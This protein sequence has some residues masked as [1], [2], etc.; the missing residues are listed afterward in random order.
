ME[1]SRFISSKNNLSIFLLISLAM[2]GVLFVAVKDLTID[3]AQQNK[4]ETSKVVLRLFRSEEPTPEPVTTAVTQPTPASTP[5]A[6]SPGASAVPA[7]APAV[8]PAAK[9]PMKGPAAATPAPVSSAAASLPDV[10]AAAATQPASAPPAKSTMQGP[11]GAPASTPAEKPAQTPPKALST[12]LPTR[13][14]ET[15]ADPTPV[16]TLQEPA[17]AAPHEK[18][19]PP[20]AEKEPIFERQKESAVKNEV[21]EGKK[22]EQIRNVEIIERA[23][24]AEAAPADPLETNEE[25]VS[26]FQTA[27]AVPEPENNH[28]EEPSPTPILG[29]I[30]TITSANRQIDGSRDTASGRLN[31]SQAGGQGSSEIVPFVSLTE[32]ARIPA[33]VY[34]ELARRWGH[35]GIAVIRLY[36]NADGTIKDVIL[37]SSSGHPE[38]DD[39]ALQVVEERWKLKPLGREVVTVKEFE[40]KLQ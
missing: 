36:V 24:G 21:T 25:Y 40:F 16:A 19:I 28:S 23:G 10:S 26:V 14:T 15:S 7:A 2:H 3:N 30:V 22:T 18:A 37:L 31:Y 33:P 27:A 12:T 39:A 29:P 32:G 34:P 13:S 35:E 1:Y 11:A 8:A 9:S 6:S 17:T 38:L 20:P 4:A 5:H